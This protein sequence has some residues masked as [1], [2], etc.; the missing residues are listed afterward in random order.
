LEV[1]QVTVMLFDWL[2]LPSH[3]NDPSEVCRPFPP[4]ASIT[5]SPW[6]TSVRNVPSRGAARAA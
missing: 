6:L 5:S 3:L 2:R 1:N 4:V